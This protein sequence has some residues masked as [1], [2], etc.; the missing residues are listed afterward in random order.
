[1]KPINEM[2]QWIQPLALG[3]AFL[4]IV[5]WVVGTFFFASSGTLHNPGDGVDCNG[6]GR[7]Y[8]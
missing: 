1:M 2:P 8:D 3:A 4:L 6:Q 7:N 5:A